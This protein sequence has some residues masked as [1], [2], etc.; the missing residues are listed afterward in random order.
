MPRAL[1]TES[2]AEKSGPLSDLNEISG[3]ANSYVSIH[4]LTNMLPLIHINSRGL[5]ATATEKVKVAAVLPVL[6]A[7]K[8][9]HVAPSH[10]QT[11]AQQTR[12]QTME[13]WK[14]LVPMM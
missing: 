13:C 4:W 10:L 11:H 6:D 5:L 3:I 8:I 1:V 14:R 7:P 2:N 12:L 9:P